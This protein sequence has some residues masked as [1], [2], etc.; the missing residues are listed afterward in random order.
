[1]I[2]NTKTGANLG[3]KNSQHHQ[4]HTHNQD[5]DTKVK[6]KP[7]CSPKLNKDLHHHRLTNQPLVA[8]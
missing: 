4:L 7:K 1:M 6:R 8:L 5:L 2:T 3:D